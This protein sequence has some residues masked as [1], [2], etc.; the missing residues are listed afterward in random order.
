MKTLLVMTALVLLA[1]CSA[2][3][4]TALN[5]PTLTRPE[6]PV[7]QADAR[8]RTPYDTSPHFKR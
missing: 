5:S 4:A 3:Y 2:P 7:T 8:A 6:A 1:G